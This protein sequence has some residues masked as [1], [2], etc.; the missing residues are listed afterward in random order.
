MRTFPQ[1]EH[2]RRYVADA[3]ELFADK[4]PG[5]EF[6][7]HRWNVTHLR[8]RSHKRSNP[9]VYWTLYGSQSEAL[10]AEYADIV[11]AACIHDLQSIT[12]LAFRADVARMLWKALSE[13]LKPNEFQWAKLTVEDLLHAERLMREAKAQSTTYKSMVSFQRVLDLLGTM[14][15]I[16][17]MADI[18]WATPRTED[19][20]RYTLDGREARM[21]LM[22]SEEAINAAAEIY[23]RYAETPQDRILAC[24]LAILLATGLRIG[25]VLALPHKP[26]LQIAGGWRLRY[27]V[28][29]NKKW[30][31]VTL[32]LTPIQAE[33]VGNAVREV[34]EI[35]ADARMQARRV[36]SNQGR[37]A[38]PGGRS[39][40]E[41]LTSGDLEA[42]LG[43][44]KGSAA[45]ISKKKLPRCIVRI[46]GPPGKYAFFR[47][48][49]V[50]NY[51]TIEQEPERWTIRNTMPR[52]ESLFVVF[53]NFMHAQRGVVRLLVEGI[54]EQQVND[55]L[56]GRFE[57]C[58]PDEVGA[59]LHEGRSGRWIMRSAFDRFGLVDAT[60][61][62]IQLTTHSFR[63]YVTTKIL[64]E[65]GADPLV[66]RW[67]NR[68]YN[69]DLHAYN[70][71]KEEHRVTLLRNGITGGRIVGEVAEMY[72]ALAED[73]RDAFLETVVQHV[74][75]T[76][77]GFCVHD[78]AAE[79]CPF[80]LNCLRGCK[81]YLADPADE[82]RRAHLV[83]IADRTRSLLEAEENQAAE[84]GIPLSENWVASH[85]Q[86]IAN[87]ERILNSQP[88]AGCKF[89]QPFAD[90][91]S[92]FEQR[93]EV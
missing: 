93:L 54:R 83:G 65:G 62:R 5:Q 85:R 63:H 38:L 7:A 51:L 92:R 45:A 19:T 16:R 18:R 56:G 14:H 49:D 17:P 64:E 24:A 33:L 20:E 75:V 13:R 72:F 44:V 10:P 12:N 29:K 90:E 36:E 6:G 8:E 89:T 61:N 91:P 31:I 42:L 1:P 27:H 82:S 88:R 69:A 86:L 2:E 53:R 32:P 76:E 34:Q 26:L 21:E 55:F 3:R 60:G 4:F 73:L 22:P 70:H 11:K 9:N 28:E 71:V 40:A 81:D 57:A 77:V 78:L 39:F 43:L 35:T 37:V 48:G 47:V 25:E 41:E 30:D 66:A 68:A 58:S 80:H 52:S 50:E 15:I 79:P 74:H 46:Q 87:I 59:T 67:Q 84:A 23:F